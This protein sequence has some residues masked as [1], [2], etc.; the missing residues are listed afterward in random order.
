MLMPFF[1]QKMRELLERIG[2]P[3]D[4]TLSLTDNFST[5][6]EVYTVREK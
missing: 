4:D 1:E 5:N 2:T 6:P 3:Y